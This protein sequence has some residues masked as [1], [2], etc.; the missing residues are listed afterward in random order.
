MYVLESTLLLSSS[1]SVNLTLV[2]DIP[3]LSP[4][5]TSVDSA[6]DI[7]GSPYKASSDKLTRTSSEAPYCQLEV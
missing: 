3:P 5:S 6:S 4:K 1:I 7:A 2:V